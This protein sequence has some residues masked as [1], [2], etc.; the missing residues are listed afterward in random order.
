MKNEQFAATLSA[1]EKRAFDAINEVIGKFLGNQKAENYREI[2]GELIEAFRV[3]KV[4]MSLKIHFLH[5]HLHFFPS[6][7]GDYSD[8]HG[9]RFHQDVAIIEKRF[10][11]KDARNMLGEYCWSICRETNIDEL[12]RKSKRPFF[13]TK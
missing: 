1:I 3:M 7:L 9:E 10:K 13:L 6:N 4:N 11:G 5:N 8:E 2:V 12:K